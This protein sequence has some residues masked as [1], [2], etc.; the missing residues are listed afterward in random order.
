MENE[1]ASSTPAGKPAQGFGAGAQWGLASLMIGSVVFI[2]SPVVL[3]FNTMFMNV[4]RFR[5]PMGLAWIA[6]LIGVVTV[7][8]IGVAG[9]VFGTRGWLIAA[10]KRRCPALPVAGTFMSIA[11]VIS[12]LIVSIDLIVILATM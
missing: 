5:V 2:A 9:I 11:A 7:L 3:V 4:G 10:R 1:V 12:W 6:S 8:A